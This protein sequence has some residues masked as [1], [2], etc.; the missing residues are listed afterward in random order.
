M[1][2]HW[3][4]FATGLVLLV[5]AVLG[6]GCAIAPAPSLSGH[7]PV[8]GDAGA[9]SGLTY[10]IMGGEP[11]VED[12]Y[13]SVVQ[14]IMPGRG[15]CSGVLI[16]PRL[17]LT[18]AH[19]FCFPAPESLEPERVYTFKKVNAQNEVVLGC[20]DKAKVSAVLYRMVSDDDSLPPASPKNITYRGGVRV[21]V[22]EGYRFYTNSAKEVVRSEMDLAAVHLDSP[23]TGVRLDSQLATS[24]VQ[25]NRFLVAVGYGFT[26]N[27]VAGI[28]HFGISRVADLGSNNTAGVFAFGKPEAPLRAVLSLT[29]DSGGPCFF[30]EGGRR[31]LI[32]I[33]S[34]RRVVDGDMVTNF[35]STFYYRDWINEQLKKSG[36]R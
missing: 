13:S 33:I 7:G 32:G 9:S 35:T 8:Q 31:W 15:T 29:G 2:P 30:E 28:R 22:S 20:A 19:C 34:H 17:V 36:V 23:M 12:R 5:T 1:F 14:V 27:Y 16:S 6:H 18:A 21:H 3:L 24:E 11:D 25:P 4:R 26:E 10:L